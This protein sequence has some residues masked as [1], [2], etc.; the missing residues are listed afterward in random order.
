MSQPLSRNST[1]IKS[2]RAGFEGG[3][4]CAPRSSRTLLI[5]PPK[6]CFHVRFITVRAVSGFFALRIQSARS[7]RVSLS[8][9]GR[10]NV[11][12]KPGVAGATI[13]PVSSRK[14]PR[15]RMRT[16]RGDLFCTVTRQRG[17]I[18]SMRPRSARATATS[19]RRAAISGALA[20]NASSSCLTCSGVRLPASIAAMDATARSLLVMVRM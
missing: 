12:R 9:F 7:R 15:G 17:S 8:F 16:V 2:I 19:S 10:P 6:N 20:T 4:P 14:L 3:A 13:S 1:A 5:P 11:P 18:C